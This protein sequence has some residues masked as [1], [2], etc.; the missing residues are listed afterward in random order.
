MKKFISLMLA[1]LVVLSLASTAFAA[2]R[3]PVY[4]VGKVLYFFDKSSG[5]IT[6]FAGESTDL[7]IPTELNG[8]KV[9]SIG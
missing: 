3:I 2:P 5:T 7:V 1:A 4:K 6:G 9:V 8:H